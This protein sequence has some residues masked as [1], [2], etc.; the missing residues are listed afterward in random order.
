MDNNTEPNYEQDL[1][2]SDD[3][4]DVLEKIEYAA[5]GADN[6]E[7]EHDESDNLNYTGSGSG[8]RKISSRLLGKNGGSGRKFAIIA[9]IGGTVGFMVTAAILL[10]ML[11]GSLQQVHFATILRSVGLARFSYTTNKQ[12]SRLTLQAAT[13]TGESTGSYDLKDR[14]LWQKVTGVNPNKALTQLGKEG[15]VRFTFD[16]NCSWGCLKQTNSFRSISIDGNE[17]KLSD[18]T[19]GNDYDKLSTRQKLAVQNRFAA[20]IETA[21]GDRLSIESRAFRSSVYNG[22]RQATG[23]SMTKWAFKAREFAGLTPKE[24]I[25]LNTKQTAERI[26]GD[27]SKTSSLDAINK[28][29]EAR[30]DPTPEKIAAAEQAR[31]K[32]ISVASATAKASIAALSL[33]AVCLVNEIDNAADATKESYEDLLARS[34]HDALTTA[35]QIKYG[36]TVHEAVN[37]ENTRWDGASNAYF[38]KKATGQETTDSDLAQLNSIPG[39]GGAS[40]FTEILGGL[41]TGIERSSLLGL[42]APDLAAEA[43][44][45][46]CSVVMNEGVQWAVAGAELVATVATSFFT[47][48]GT[49]AGSAAVRAAIFTAIRGAAEMG[50]SVGLGELLGSLLDKVIDSYSSFSGTETDESLYNTSAIGVDYLQE[51]GTRQINYGAPMNPEETQDIQLAAEQSLRNS[52]D[53]TSFSNRYF[54]IT[55]PFSFVGRLVGNLPSSFS[56][57]VNSTFNF[58]PN[59]LST[60]FSQMFTPAYAA[61]TVTTADFSSYVSQWG[62]TVN[63]LNR[64]GTDESFTLENLSRYYEKTWNTDEGAALFGKYDSCYSSVYQREVP[65]YCTADFLRTDD[66]LKYRA[67]NSYYVLADWSSSDD[68]GVRDAAIETTSTVT[69]Q[70]DTGNLSDRA[71]LQSSSDSTSC[72]PRTDDLGIHTGSANKVSVSIRLCAVK[73]LNSSDAESNPGGP[74]YIEGANGHAIVNAKISTAMVNMVTAMKADPSITS[75]RATSSFRSSERQTYLYNLYLQGKGNKASPPGTSNHEMGLAVDFKITAAS[76]NKVSCVIKNG[77]CTP[78]TDSYSIY[79]WLTSQAQQYGFSQYSGEWWH[80]EAIGV[81]GN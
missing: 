61:S 78:P 46:G 49:A 70:P 45:V 1:K 9:G 60:T 16:S 21:L 59:Q 44:N 2:N 54:A 40:L 56:S 65:D 64:A 66:A 73:E 43:Q 27:V 24:A 13:L 34:G 52:Y 69:A 57:L 12:L 17:Y 76:Q 14:N 19:N 58:I 31:A 67:Y 74:Y 75:L 33:T 63:E 11:L 32:A 28:E 15:T 8:K 3:P 77:I 30:A 41:D 4:R 48:G 38:Y 20:S 62:W 72:D 81:G 53:S 26:S 68:L 51:T 37:A 79:S 35:D 36:D 55:N 22:L 5:S 42:F 47:A 6:P 50:A 23:I 7:T 25:E 71:Y 29:N 80:W 39:M 10:L 18:F